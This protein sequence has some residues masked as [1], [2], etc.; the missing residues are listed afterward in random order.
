MELRPS[1]GA[2]PSPVRILIV[3]DTP[4]NL[5]AYRETLQRP[6][7]TIVTADNGGAALQEALREDFAAVL[8]DVR[9][10]GMTGLEI[11]QI[12]RSRERFKFTPIIFISAYDRMPVDV[13]NGYLAGCIDY[14]FSPVDADLLRFKVNACVELHLWNAS[15]RKEIRDLKEANQQLQRNLLKTHQTLRSS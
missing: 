8:L 15:L 9:M 3:D 1:P 6:G 13:A 5:L 10:P 7:W 11:A 12:L 14:L 4:A 2:D